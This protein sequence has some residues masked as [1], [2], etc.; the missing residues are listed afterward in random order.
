MK[1]VKCEIRGIAF[2]PG[3]KGTFDNV[4]SF[5]N[6]SIMVLGQDFDC[7]KSYKISFENGKEDIEKN[8][9]WRN[10]LKFLKEVH[11][12]PNDCFF[13]NAIMGIRK[14]D[15][16]IGKSPAFED[17]IFIK[18]CREFF[19]SQLEIQKPK[20][21]FVLGKYVAEFLSPTSK[22]LVCWTEIKDFK[23]IDE[24]NI[25]IKKDVVFDNGIKTNLVLLTHPSY[26]PVNIHRRSFKKYTGHDAE[27]MM[28]KEIL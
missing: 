14:G 2:F 21:I 15:I 9:T 10:L 6:K 26:R 7:E 28:V 1:K 16:G 3:G 4:D 19:L 22:Y 5:S 25:Q 13:T 20:A 18:E 17:K 24:K 11:I 27:I 8:P 23:T 12:E